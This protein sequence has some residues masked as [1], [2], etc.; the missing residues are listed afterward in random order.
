[1][2]DTLLRKVAI[3]TGAASGIGRHWAGVLAGRPEQYRLMLVDANEDALR[4]SFVPR[5]GLAARGGRVRRHSSKP[6]MAVAA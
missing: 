6:G 5:D 2:P 4:D 1:M 3:V